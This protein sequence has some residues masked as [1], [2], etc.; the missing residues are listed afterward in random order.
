MVEGTRLSLAPEELAAFSVKLEGWAVES[1]SPR[2]RAFLEQML[3]DAAD[4]ANED[5]SGYPNLTSVVRE[6]REV[7]AYAAG[8]EAGSLSGAVADYA[9]GW[10]RQ[11]EDA[12]ADALA[13]DGE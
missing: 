4:A 9:A 3:A 11:E 2:E 5:P 12:A 6:D 7:A 8:S 13:I 10:A 1:L